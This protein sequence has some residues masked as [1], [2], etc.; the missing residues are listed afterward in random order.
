MKHA[1]FS[2]VYNELPFLKQKIPFLY[3]NFHQI[4]FYDLNIFDYTFSNDGTHEYIKNFPDP[5]KKIKLIEKKDLSDVKKYDGASFVNKRKMFAV[6][7]KHIR[8][9]IDVFWCTDADEFFTKGLIEEVDKFYS[10]GNKGCFNV[11]HVIYYKDH[12]FAFCENGNE[13]IRYLPRIVKHSPGN[14]YG[15]CNLAQRFSPMSWSKNVLHHFAYVGDSRVKFK[16]KVYNLSK[17]TFLKKWDNFDPNFKE[18]ILHGIHPSM[19]WGLKR[20]KI[21]LPAYINIKK[22]LK[23]LE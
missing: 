3:R 21:P 9:D 7:S 5:E 20:S 1:H 13:K 12:R 18:E 10:A 2:I 23:E 8:N 4:V 17:E 19:S 15:H 11:P 22:M 6:G 16:S 14:L